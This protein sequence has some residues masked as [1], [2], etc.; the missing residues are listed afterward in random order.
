MGLTT[1]VTVWLLLHPVVG[2]VMVYTY[3][4]VTA[5]CVVL[6]N[7]SDTLPVPEAAALLIPVTA[8]LVQL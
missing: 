4:T 3:A 2:L 5:D 6:I 7:V 1:T 8:A